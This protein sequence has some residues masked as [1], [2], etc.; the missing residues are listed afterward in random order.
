MVALPHAET[1]A[2]A[3]RD[4]CAVLILTAV[5]AAAAVCGGGN[6]A[7]NKISKILFARLQ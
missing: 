7:I 4:T 3:C 6:I 5:A 1:T 2:S